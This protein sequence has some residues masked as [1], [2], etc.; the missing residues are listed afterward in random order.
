MRRKPCDAIKRKIRALE[1]RIGVD[2]DGNI[3]RIRDAPEIGF[4]LR[5]GKRKVRFQ[6]RQNAVGTELLI[7]D[8]LRQASDVEVE[9]T[10]ATTGTRPPA[11]SIVACTTRERCELSR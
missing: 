11:A 1:L 7:R 8:R 10:P 3:D 4:H 9:A 2:H 6:N 5:V